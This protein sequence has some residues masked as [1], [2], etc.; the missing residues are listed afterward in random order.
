MKVMKCVLLIGSLWTALVAGCATQVSPASD[1]SASQETSVSSE[2]SSG[3]GGLPTCYSLCQRRFPC[4]AQT[5][6]NCQK[7]SDCLDVCDASFPGC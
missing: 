5:P 4:T 7:L 1:D 2:L 6:A 3:C